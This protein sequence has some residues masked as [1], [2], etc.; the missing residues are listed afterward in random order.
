VVHRADVRGVRTADG[1]LVAV[2]TGL[3]LL[4]D[5]VHGGLFAEPTIVEAEFGAQH[6]ELAH[7][8]LRRVG[9]ALGPGVRGKARNKIS[10]LLEGDR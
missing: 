8:L 2:D 3:K 10:Y 4:V 6:R 9:E 5:A 7:A 1:D